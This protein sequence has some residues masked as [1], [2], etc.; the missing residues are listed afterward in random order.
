VPIRFKRENGQWKI[1]AIGSNERLLE[2]LKQTHVWKQHAE[3]EA[4]FGNVQA[5]YANKDWQ[6]LTDC[7][8][9]TGRVCWARY[10]L[11]EP[12]NL[13]G[14][15]ADFPAAQENAQAEMRAL[16]PNFASFEASDLAVMRSAAFDRLIAQACVAKPEDVRGIFSQATELLSEDFSKTSLSTSLIQCR[17]R[18]S[19]SSLTLSDL[20]VSGDVGSGAL[21]S[22]DSSRLAKVAFRREAGRWKFDMVMSPEELQ[23]LMRV[24]LMRY[25][26]RLLPDVLDSYQKG[27]WLVASESFTTAGQLRW[28]LEAEARAQEAQPGLSSELAKR[29]IEIRKDAVERTKHLSS[30]DPASMEEFDILRNKLATSNIAE[31]EQLLAVFCTSNPPQNIQARFML[32]IADLSACEL[33]FEPQKFALKDMRISETDPETKVVASLVD[34]DLPVCFKIDHD[35]WKI[36]SLGSLEQLQQHARL[37]LQRQTDSPRAVVETFREAMADG[38]FRTALSCMSEDARNEWLG[39]M[40]IGCLL[41]NPESGEAANSKVRYSGDE[42]RIIRSTPNLPL[43]DLLSNWQEAI[44]LPTETLSRGDRRR[45]AI[46]LGKEIMEKSPW[47]LMPPILSTR[48]GGSPDAFGSAL[49]GKLEEIPAHADSVGDNTQ[50]KYR[51]QPASPDQPPLELDIIQVDGLWKL[52]TIIDP[53]LKPWPLPTEEPTPPAEATPVDGATG[54][55]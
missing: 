19:L 8:T 41:V 13:M 36:D 7:F 37:F 18:F 33:P 44:E 34:S 31:I 28:L 53:A 26:V 3:I 29:R 47:N 12:S 11:T 54:V 46:E 16:V 9:H 30:V 25:L 20:Q 51:L 10:G 4:V 49:W 40:M 52:N 42:V 48:F 21:V 14:R 38:R 15:P 55:P 43:D 24:Q 32:A 23:S 2:R 27:A 35:K 6:K 39:E 50:M 17:D 5:A 45:V 1:D 22:A